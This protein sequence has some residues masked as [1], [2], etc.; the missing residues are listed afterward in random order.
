MQLLLYPAALEQQNGRKNAALPE[1]ERA[2]HALLASR[3]LRP[4]SHDGLPPVQARCVAP[5]AHK[6]QMSARAC[7]VPAN[8]TAH[9]PSQAA[10]RPQRTP[11]HAGVLCAAHA[12]EAAC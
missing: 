11:R 4:G 6:T 2:R 12:A 5:L 9:A 7:C 8:F 1:P 10:A 3:R